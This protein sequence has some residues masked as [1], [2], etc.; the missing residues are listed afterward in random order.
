MRSL[1]R[2]VDLDRVPGSI[3]L[4][5]GPKMTSNGSSEGAATRGIA[6][7][8]MQPGQPYQ[9]TYIERFNRTTRTQALD[10]GSFRSIQ[11]VQHIT[12]DGGSTSTSSALKNPARSAPRLLRAR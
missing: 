4:D 6:L 12:G 8:F 5:R 1:S 2:L 10:A 11:T 3:R 9:T 7:R